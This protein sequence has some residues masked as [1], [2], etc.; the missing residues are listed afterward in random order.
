MT[1]SP[2]A[3]D[4]LIIVDVQ[5]DFLPG[6]ALAVPDGDKV[7]PVINTLALKFET[8]ILT[9]D[10]HPRNHISFASN[11]P[12][13]SINEEINVGYGK[14]ILWPDHCVQDTKG[15]AISN[16]LSVPHARL[17]IRKGTDPNIDSYSAFME[18]AWK[19]MD[20]AGVNRIRSSCL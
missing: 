4:L 7:V 15:A 2:I 17:I 9:Q 20:N 1:Y 8:I 19:S 6:G 3:S 18:A 11:H 14:Q 10:W 12:E 16:E 5:N 13:K